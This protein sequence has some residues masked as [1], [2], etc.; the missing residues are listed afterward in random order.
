MTEQI[1]TPEQYPD[2]HIA[3]VIAEH[4]KVFAG[5]IASEQNK[6]DAEENWKLQNQIFKKLENQEVKCFES[7]KIKGQK[8]EFR[9]LYEKINPVKNE[10]NQNCEEEKVGE[11]QKKLMLENLTKKFHELVITMI[12][13]DIYQQTKIQAKKFGINLSEE[14]LQEKVKKFRLLD[15]GEFNWKINN[16]G[17]LERTCYFDWI[18]EKL[19]KIEN[20]DLDKKVDGSSNLTD[21]DKL[22][23]KIYKN[24][25]KQ[26]NA[27]F[28]GIVKTREEIDELEKNKAKEIAKYKKDQQQNSIQ[29]S[30]NPNELYFN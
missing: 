29:N 12:K 1:K 3:Q 19:E 7:S 21:L 17:K 10:K 9:K 25:I 26:T 13:A 8:A 15:Y 11:Y 24:S 28:F 22:I 14:T 2:N 5:G 27:H 4:P 23:L 20:L 16:Q 18:G 30:I 6:N